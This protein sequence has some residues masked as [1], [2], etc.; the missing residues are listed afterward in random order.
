MPDQ[1]GMLGHAVL[2]PESNEVVGMVSRMHM[3]L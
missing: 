1:V 3:L 2:M